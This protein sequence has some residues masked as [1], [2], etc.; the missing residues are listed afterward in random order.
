M[1]LSLENMTSKY[2][3]KGT[4]KITTIY[5][6]SKY[7]ILNVSFNEINMMFLQTVGECD[8]TITDLSIIFRDTGKNIVDVDDIQITCEKIET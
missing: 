4:Y 2:G 8:L 3:W 5:V 7:D 6:K 1:I